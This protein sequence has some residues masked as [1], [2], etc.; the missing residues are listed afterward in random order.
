MKAKKIKQVYLIAIL[1]MVFFPPGISRAQE[2]CPEPIMTE[3]GLVSG[4]SNPESAACEWMGVPYA[5]APVEELRWKAPGPHPAW[6]G[7]R[8]TNAFGDRCMQKA[9]IG[10]KNAQSL[11]GM[12]EDCLYLNIYRPRKSGV[13]P[14]MFWIHGGGYVFGSGNGYRGDRLAEFGEVVVVTINYRLGVF[15]FLASP[16]LKSEDPNQ[17]TGN[18]GMLDMVAALKWVNNNIKNFGGDPDNIT[19]F[20]ESAGSWAVCTLLATPLT[21]GLFERAIMESQ[22]CNASED[23]DKGYRKS[24]AIAQ[25]LGC[26]PDDFKCLRAIPSLKLLNNAT[27]N[28]LKKGFP[29]VAHHDGF[30]LA[31]SPLNLIRKGAYN[32]VPL[33]AGSNRDEFDILSFLWPR[34]NNAA[35]GEYSKLTRRNLSLSDQEW[36]KFEGAYP[37][38][39]YQNRPR[40]AFKKAL[41]D[42]GITCPTYLGIKAVAEHQTETYY[43]RFDYDQIKYGLGALHSMEIP[44]VFN[45]VDLGA[46]RS[47][48]G[49]NLKDAQALSKIMAG[50][51]TNF[52]KTG[53]P[54]GKGLPD[55]PAFD[56]NRRQTQ[57]LDATVQTGTAEIDDRCSFWDEYLENHPPFLETLAKPPK[58]K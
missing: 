46:A 9:M 56:L 12:N 30:F 58:K 37:L 27:P 41:S 35:P 23:L 57:I 11:E 28:L 18:Y 14:V 21:K 42:A 1:A 34:L 50:Y 39:K 32:R 8:N 5:A 36:K 17:S 52:A 26:A 4:M 2:R 43:Y 40:N 3:S 44:F 6:S 29:F 54:N 16:E 33:I 15:G 48:Y 19:I 20:G 24:S 10:L 22:G 13:F 38:S 31:D 47:L 51:W 55:W 53:N 49:K 25:E 45:S 7:A